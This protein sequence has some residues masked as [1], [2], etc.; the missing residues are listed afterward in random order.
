MPAA[1][2]WK[3]GDQF[4][5]LTVTGPEGRVKAG[6]R[7]LRAVLC[8]CECGAATMVPLSKL[9][10][11]HTRSCGC[12]QRRAAQDG[13]RHAQKFSKGRRAEERPFAS[14]TPAGQVMRLAQER[15]PASA[16]PCEHAD[17]SCKGRTEWASRSGE[18][19][20]PGDYMALCRSHHN[21]YARMMAGLM[22]ALG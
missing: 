21:R 12:L 1:L 7:M 11:G 17:A 16:W 10:C 13:M 9:H 5:M 18:R 20:G 19:S 15:G 4:G 14:L 22:R 8:E 6:S 2:P 3:P